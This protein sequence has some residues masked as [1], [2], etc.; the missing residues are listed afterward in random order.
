MRAEETQFDKEPERAMKYRV[1]G[2]YGPKESLEG[3]TRGIV[4]ENGTLRPET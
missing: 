2:N 1:A 3:L 4:S